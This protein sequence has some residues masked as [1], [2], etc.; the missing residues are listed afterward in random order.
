MKIHIYYVAL[1]ITLALGVGAG[2]NN[3]LVHDA[4]NTALPAN[5]T[6]I[7]IYNDDVDITDQCSVLVQDRQITVT[8]KT[9]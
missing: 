9:E 6:T 1:L 5:E 3:A 8:W 4:F 2:C 7:T